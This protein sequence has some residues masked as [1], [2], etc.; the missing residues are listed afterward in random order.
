MRGSER[1][2]VAFGYHDRIARLRLAAIDDVACEDPRV[3][4]FNAAGGFAV[5]GDGVQLETTRPDVEAFPPFR[6]GGNA[7]QAVILARV[8]QVHGVG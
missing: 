1:A 2:S 4:A 3:S 7:L 8:M 5:Y 6:A